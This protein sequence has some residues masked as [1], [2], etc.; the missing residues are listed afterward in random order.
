MEES[1]NV[2]IQ[3]ET[4]DLE[5]SLN[6][7]ELNFKIENLRLEQNL[8]FAII[9]SLSSAIVMAILWAAITVTT[10]YQIG[11]MAIAVGFAV[12]FAVRFTGKGIDKIYGIIG[13]IGALLGCV[14]G[15]FLSQVGF[16]AQ[17]PEIEM[18]YFEGLKFLLTDMR[19]TFE[20]MK[21]TFSP[22][23]LLFYGIAIYEGYRFSFRTINSHNYATI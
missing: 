20:I 10:K 19:L 17:D 7:E 23:D 14:L 15:N 13:A 22:I 9:A 8:P 12:G 5:Q 21:E 2:E 6:Q 1:K 18:S 4:Q 11:Y 3:Q 16:I